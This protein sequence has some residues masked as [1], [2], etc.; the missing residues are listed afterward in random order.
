LYA[1]RERKD[2]FQKE[3]LIIVELLYNSREIN[4]KFCINKYGNKVIFLK[5]LIW[6]KFALILLSILFLLTGCSGKQKEFNSIEEAEKKLGTIIDTPS[7]PVDF[8]VSKVYYY[9]DREHD[10]IVKIYY[11]NEKGKELKFIIA[12]SIEFGKEQQSEEIYRNEINEMKWIKADSD[13]ILKWKRN[14]NESYKYLITKDESDKE[15]LIR[16]AEQYDY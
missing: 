3:L 8:R 16:I 6:T 14:S 9:D 11:K 4:Y 1:S 5:K 7:I 10:P 12:S 15:Q 13:Y 2:K